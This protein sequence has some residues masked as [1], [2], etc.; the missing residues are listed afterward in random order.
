MRR[1]DFIFN[2]G[3]LIV[4]SLLSSDLLANVHSTS[5]LNS[6]INIGVIGSGGRG[7]GI[8]KLL[9]SIPGYNVV[10]VC[11]NIPFRLEEGYQFIKD[12]KEPKAYHDHRKLL[13]NKKIDAVVIST[14]LSSH[15]KIAI[16]AVDADKHVYCEKTLAKGAVATASIVNKCKASNKIFQTGHQFHSSR[17]YTQL[18][19]LIAGGKV[20]KISSI[21]AQWNRNGNWRRTVSDLAL[22]RQ[23]NWRMYREYSYGLLAELSSHQI[24]FTNW[25]LNST[26]Q[27]VIGFGGINYWKDGRETYDN[28]KVI[29]EYRDGVKATFTCLTSNAKDNY[30][31]MVMGDKGTLTIFQET[32]WFF[33]EGQYIPQYGEVDGV[34][35]ATTN[36]SQGKG[37][38]L[39]MNH[40]DPTKQALIDFKDSILDNQ[41]PLSGV[42]TGAKSA[43]AVEM[44]IRAMDTN[45]LVLWDDVN[46]TL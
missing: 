15:D 6:I 34:S 14:P 9:N 31:I 30:K 32:A 27:K 16:D 44:G 39:D 4:S 17:M 7:K 12:N 1:K 41:T 18:V 11:D 24:D 25:I 3:G 42:I 19:E 40:I 2:T 21:E 37:I 35:G 43:Y 28:T 13:E 26:P 10:A 33:P 36:W 20:G 23:I 22:E 5:N 38:P 45:K 46:F 8:I 29:Y